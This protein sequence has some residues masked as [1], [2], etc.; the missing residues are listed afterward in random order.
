MR[1]HSLILILILLV[2]WGVRL[3]YW[4]RSASFGHYELSYD[5]DEYFQLGVLFSH[6]DFLHDPYPLRYTRSPG[7]PL[8]LAP[9]F[10]AFG[11]R[12]EIALAFQVG[13]SVLIVALMYVVSRRAFGS[14]AGIAAIALLAISPTFASTAG[15]FVLT[16][17]L[18]SFLILLFIYLFWRWNEEGMTLP[19]AL[20]AGLVLGSCALVRPIAVYFLLV[21]ALWFL[22]AN[23][24]RWR[25]ALVR[26]AVT[27]IGMLL[28]IL[29][30]TARNYVVYQRF[31]LIDTISG[32][33]M[34]R[35]HRIEGDDFWTT[36]PGIQNPG[37]R[38]RYA[39]S[40]GV[41]NILADPVRQLVVN[42]IANWASLMRP[43][44]DAFARGGGYLSDVIVDAPT[45]PLVVL[46]DVYYL[47]VV[48]LGIG[49][50][51]SKWKRAPKLLL[52]WLA[53]FLI[54]V[55]VYHTQSRFRPHYL[56]VLIVFAGAAIAQGRA[57]FQSMS[58]PTRLVWVGASVLVLALAY[59][60]RLAPLFVSE[61]YIA[62]AQGRDI[63]A[64]EQA[65]AAYPDYV[66]AY[67]ALGDA[68][69]R[70]SDFERALEAYDRALGLN[71]YELQ[72]RLGRM[73]VFRQ[74]G[75]V[76]KLAQ[77]ARAAGIESGQVRVPAPLWW[78][79]DPAP[80]RVVEL[81]NS[82]QSFGYFLN[83]YAAQRDGEESLRFT[84]DR[85]FV[86]FPGIKGWKPERLVFYARAV[87]LPDQHLPVIT[88][89]FNGREV[90]HVALTAEWQ[91]HEILL[92]DAARAEDTLIVEFR[93][94]TF[95]PSDMLPGSTDTR[96]LGFMTGYVELR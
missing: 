3:A 32:W 14:R 29:P 87:P 17:T 15:S 42:G 72:A 93:T 7:L 41:S 45:L 92:D 1:R 75:D 58:R 73:D 27:G 11:P 16:E 5:D 23:R 81:G 94:P 48:V 68:Y 90:A 71:P 61:Y 49:G 21:V 36:L 13:V 2:A 33:T 59:S 62:R 10:A 66:S 56:F 79:F 91:D 12:I 51:L 6:G 86:K 50:I 64:L 77:E 60:P 65:V 39:F 25:W 67:D 4:E 28:L 19:R 57:L 80:T 85:S 55:F 47:V 38:D 88:V 30:Y 31:I 9:V 54:I 70:Q 84:Q 26:V 46:D 43:E 44:L 96:E 34:W 83:F 53:Y 35:D 78:S 8:F 52:L 82:T 69:R 40:R 74:Q 89:R 37:D 18:F 63:D 24:S 95:R 76:E 20:A 22:Y